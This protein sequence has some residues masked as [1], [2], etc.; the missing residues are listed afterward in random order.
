MTI[1]TIR[2]VGFCAHYSAP[3]DWAFD[4]AL[5]LAQRQ[6]LPLNVFHFLSDPYDPTDDTSQV[7]TGEAR[8]RLAIAREKE[9]RLYYDSKAGE[10]LDVGFRLCED[11]EWTELH[12]CLLLRQFQILVLGYPTPVASFAGKPIEEFADC[13]V[14]PT[15]LVG[16][17][18]SG[19]YHLNSRAALI[20]DQISLAPGSWKLIQPVAK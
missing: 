16:P 6:S 14:S 1:T 17:H 19:Q 3:G 4:F 9:L 11:N 8:T 2:A 5:R 12:R 20:A 18:H 13:F 10:Y 7:V 15:V